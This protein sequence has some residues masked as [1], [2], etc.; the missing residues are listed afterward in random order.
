ME[1]KK[2]LIT[3]FSYTGNTRRLAESIREYTGGDLVEIEVLKPYP[4]DY[5]TT[6]AQGQREVRNGY[7][8]AVKTQIADIEQYDTI[9][10][11]SPIWWFTFAPAVSTFL[12]KY[13]FRAKKIIPF[14]THGGYGIGSS[15]S[16]MQALCPQAHVLKGWECEG[17]RIEETKD[18]IIAWCKKIVG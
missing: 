6:V 10:I 7:K 9:F 1:T 15:I 5:N 17:T 13:D 11:G 3:Y 4:K 2:I 12:S 14:F 8:P 16:D 18:R